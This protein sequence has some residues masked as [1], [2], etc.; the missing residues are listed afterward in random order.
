MTEQPVKKKAEFIQ[1]DAYPQMLS[2]ANAMRAAQTLQSPQ[3]HA[4]A[5]YAMNSYT[6][7]L[8]DV[9]RDYI[10]AME[11][12]GTD[13]AKIFAILHEVRGFAENAGMIT[14]GRIADSLCRYMDE[15]ERVKK[16]VDATI[17]AL[18]VQAIGRA[19]RADH[20]DPDMTDTVAAE[21]NALV[22]RRLAEAGVR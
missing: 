21:L 6:P 7:M 14:T 9:I 1:P 13:T 10:E 3:V 11:E 20:H 8:Q 5:Q 16:P 22:M 17:I 12:A 18:H 15:M 4:K 2:K 19:A